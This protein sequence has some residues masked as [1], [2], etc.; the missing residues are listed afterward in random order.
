MIGA[1][2]SNIGHTEATSGLCALTKVILSFEN[3]C[4]PPNLHFN[5]PNPKIDGLMSGILK[6][7]N[8][9]TPF[10]GD[11]VAMNNFGFGGSNVH[12]IVKS[13]KIKAK[14][15]NN[16]II[17][18]IPR[19]VQMCGRNEKTINYFFNKLMNNTN[20]ITRD[21]LSLINEI[22]KTSPFQM[23]SGLKGMKFRGFAIIENSDQNTIKS[24]N[25][26]IEK[27]SK[28]KK[29]IWFIFSGM[30]TQ[31][32]AMAK[33]LINIE[34]F[35]NSIRKSCEVLN[36]Y[37]INLWKLLTEENQNIT[38]SVLN[39]FITIAAIQIAFVDLLNELD[40]RPDGIIGHSI[41]EVVCAYADGCI[42]AEE[43]ILIAYWRG[44][45]VED[46]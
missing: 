6:P 40:I 4:I 20:K 22:S 32:S 25:V 13:P 14:E 35:S 5:K 43:T 42:T 30:G 2:K 12:V 41:G 29:E 11:L 17:D 24:T 19:L 36:K 27:V 39:S 9:N 7:I 28:T 31:W 46:I 26:E 3:E 38:D 33:S 23:N 34:I 18:E 16:R 37:E 45:C 15:D 1:L 8:E 44:K 21:S 10:Y